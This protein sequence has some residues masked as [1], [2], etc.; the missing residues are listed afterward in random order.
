MRGGGRAAVGLLLALTLAACGAGP[1]RRGP[2]IPLLSDMA[3]S[4]PY[5]TYAPNPVTRDGKTLQRPVP[6]TIPQGHRPFPFAA[7]LEDAERAGR[8]LANPL[9]ATPEALVRG[10]QLYATY[11][12]VCHGERG[13]G[14]GPLVPKIPNPPSYTSA[15]VRSLPAGRI[16]HVITRGSGRMG[17]Y[18]VQ[19]SPEDRWRLVHYV[20]GLMGQGEGGS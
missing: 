14:D 8:E 20:Q 15:E 5:D 1:D 18:A 9:P 10:R 2:D 6:G 12:Q 17:S 7:T 19:I 4:L 13:L 11:C 3:E 16:F